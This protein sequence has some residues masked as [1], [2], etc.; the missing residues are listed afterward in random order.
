MIL[1]QWARQSSSCFLVVK[2][3][4]LVLIVNMG[5]DLTSRDLSLNGDAGR[6]PMAPQSLKSQSR[7]DWV[8]E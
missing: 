7:D 1:C 8:F 3:L 2:E 5:S 4:E 6:E